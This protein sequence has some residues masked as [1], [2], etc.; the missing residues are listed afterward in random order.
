VEDGV[1]PIERSPPPP[2]QAT[3]DSKKVEINAK[4]IKNTMSF[5]ILEVKK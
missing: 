5:L 1:A 3:S 4:R 2:P